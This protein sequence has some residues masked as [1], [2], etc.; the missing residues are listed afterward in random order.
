MTSGAQSKHGPELRASRRCCDPV[1][2]YILGGGGGLVLLLLI[3]VGAVFSKQKKKRKSKMKKEEA[4]GWACLRPGRKAM[5]YLLKHRRK[6]QLSGKLLI[7]FTQIATKVPVVYRVLMPPAV[8][9][10]ITIFGF[11]SLDLDAFGL[12][13]RCLGIGSFFNRLLTMAVAPLVAMLVV[14][15]A[16][17]VLTCRE[18][19]KRQWKNGKRHGEGTNT[20]ASGNKY[21]G[22]FRDGNFHGLGKYTFANGEV[23]HGEFE[24]GQPKE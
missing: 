12:P 8:Q 3:V 16:S 11:A 6:I 13:W 1:P 22:Q 17:F 24:N 5:R 10:V 15:L 9:G 20:Y 4:E 23:L 14:L 18:R 19:R 7:S 21:V 2:Y